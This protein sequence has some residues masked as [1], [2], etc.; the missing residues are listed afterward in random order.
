MDIKTWET[1]VPRIQSGSSD[2]LVL[3]FVD[4]DCVIY[5]CIFLYVCLGWPS[6]CL[7][8]CP[9]HSNSLINTRRNS[10]TAV[11]LQ[12]LLDVKF[13]S[14]LH[15]LMRHW[16]PSTWNTALQSMNATLQTFGC[17]LKQYFSH[18]LFSVAGPAAWICLS[19][20][21]HELVLT[22]NSFR[23]LLKTRLFAEY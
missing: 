17:R 14:E 18:G 6:V 19:D 22:A 9:S 2:F 3:G 8:V 5:S 13:Y 10:R 4:V 16:C 15:K 11:S 12:T 7:S 23:Q 20:E 1:D 21:L